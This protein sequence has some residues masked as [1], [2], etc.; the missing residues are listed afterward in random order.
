MRIEI[1]CQA[2]EMTNGFLDKLSFI[3]DCEIEVYTNSNIPITVPYDSDRHKVCIEDSN[4]SKKL[5]KRFLKD[6]M[7]QQLV[8]KTI[9]KTI[10]KLN[11]NH[12]EVIQLED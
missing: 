9:F 7:L 12:S 1:N 8:I 4:L 3:I 5:K 2:L 10:D 6:D 11:V